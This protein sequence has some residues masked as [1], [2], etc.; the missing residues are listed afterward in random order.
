MLD[1][2]YKGVAIACAVTSLLEALVA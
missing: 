2:F 1:K